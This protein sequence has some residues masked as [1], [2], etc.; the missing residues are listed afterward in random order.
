MPCNGIRKVYK[1]AWKMPE[2]KN[3]MKKCR[4]EAN[5]HIVISLHIWYDLADRIFCE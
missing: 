4:K 5:L 1:S 2:G 3:R